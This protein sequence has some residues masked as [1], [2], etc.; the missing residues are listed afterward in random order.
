[1]RSHLSVDNAD[2]NVAR[3]TRAV[4]TQHPGATLRF[5]FS[6]C[7]NGLSACYFPQGISY[8]PL[9][10]LHIFKPTGPGRPPARDLS[11]KLPD[12]QGSFAGAP[13]SPNTGG[14]ESICGERGKGAA[15]F[16]CMRR[17]RRCRPHRRQREDCR[18]WRSPIRP[19]APTPGRANSRRPR[20]RSGNSR[21]R[22]PVCRW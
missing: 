2:R 12:K 16:P 22:F 11:C 20:S 13:F 15:I 19:G 10:R 3:E 14:R 18:L 6:A 7:S 8:I 21:R 1:M 9:N 17:A 5:L 4:W